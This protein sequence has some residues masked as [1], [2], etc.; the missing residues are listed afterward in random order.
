MTLRVKYH[1][2][3]SGYGYEVFC[4]TKT[5][6]RYYNRDIDSGIWSRCIDTDYF[7]SGAIVNPEIIFDIVVDGTVLY[8]DGNGDFEGKIPYRPFVG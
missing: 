3:E 6:T 2:D 7:E 1:H 5:P 4:T 8:R